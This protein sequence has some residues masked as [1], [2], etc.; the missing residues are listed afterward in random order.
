MEMAKVLKQHV[1]GQSLYSEIVNKK[2]VHVDGWQFAG[3]LLGLFARVVNVEDLSK[4]NETKWKAEVEVYNLK[5][6]SVVGRGFAICSSSEG[7]KKGFDEYAILSMAQTRAIGKAYR[8]LLGWVMKTA[9]YESTPAE[10][11]KKKNT[12]S[13]PMT[14]EEM[15]GS[16]GGRVVEE[17]PPKTVEV[18]NKKV[19]EPADYGL[20]NKYCDKLKAEVLKRAKKEKMTDVQIIRFIN[21]QLAM[22]VKQIKSP[23]QAQMIIARFEQKGKK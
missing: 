20:Q 22:D 11:L 18:K 13:D 23:G 14:P 1:V 21:S 4:A 19:E 3:G 8:N 16:M 10:E 15:A 2:Y 6:N 9:G 7:K 17:M 12:A 5:D